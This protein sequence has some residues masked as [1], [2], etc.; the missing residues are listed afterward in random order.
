LL[1]GPMLQ[2]HCQNIP[3]SLKNGH[4]AYRKKIKQYTHILVVLSF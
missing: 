3:F 1:F 2:L 4:E